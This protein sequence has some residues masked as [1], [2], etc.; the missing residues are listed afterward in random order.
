MTT[1]TA[2]SV[3]LVGASGLRAEVEVL[4]WARSFAAVLVV[5]YGSR[6]DAPG[7]E[8]VAHFA[9]HL[10]VL[11]DPGSQDPGVPVF[12]VTEID[13]TVYRAAGDPAN[14]GPVLRR[15]LDIAEGRQ[16]RYGPEVFEGERRAVTIETRRMDHQPMLRLGPMLAA[17]AATESGLDAIGRTSTASVA[18]IGAEDVADAVRRG[19]TPAN[20]RLFVAG[21]PEILSAVAADLDRCRAGRVTG[22]SATGPLATGPAGAGPGGLRLPELDGLVAVTL[23]RPR[24]AAQ[25]ELDALLDPGGPVLALGTATALPPVGRVRIAGRAQQVD[26]VVWRGA[27]A[28]ATLGRRLAALEHEDRAELLREPL[29]RLRTRAAVAREQQSVTPAGRAD[30]SAARFVFP[31]GPSCAEEVS[32]WQITEG[33][34]DRVGRYALGDS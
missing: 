13:R 18:R 28:A 24:S 32:L 15:L 34:P 11:S 16:H 31:G 21:P 19:Y 7:N 23:R 8:G 2:D 33:V 9:E 4:P 14:P 6:D 1:A 22:P 20:A 30:D 26:V 3:T 17:A 10:M 27:E 29:R 12:A 5:G 25:S